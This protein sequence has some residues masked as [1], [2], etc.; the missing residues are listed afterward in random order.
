MVSKLPKVKLTEADKIWLRGI[1]SKISKGIPVDKRTLLIELLSQLPRNFNPSDIDSRLLR[2]DVNITVVGMGLLNPQSAL[3]R[4]TN[5]VMQGIRELL[6][7][8]PKI[9]RIGVGDI[10]ELTGLAEDQVA[11]IFEKLSQFGMFSDSGTSYG[12]I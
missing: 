5:R 6:S 2:G 7:R 9:E 12:P 10:S 11:V 1:Y 8:N 4:K 3:I